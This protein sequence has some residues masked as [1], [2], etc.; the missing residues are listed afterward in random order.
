MRD[1]STFEDVIDDVCRMAGG[2]VLLVG[3]VLGPW[4]AIIAVVQLLT[5]WPL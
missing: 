1:E 3:A 2:F 4:A 5:G